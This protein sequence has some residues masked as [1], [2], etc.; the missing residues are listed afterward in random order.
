MTLCHEIPD[1]QIFKTCLYIVDLRSS[2]LTRRYYYCTFHSIFCVDCTMIFKDSVIIKS[3]LP[4]F[5]RSYKNSY[6]SKCGYL[7]SCIFQLHCEEG[8]IIRPMYSRAGFYFGFIRHKH[9][10]SSKD[11][12]RFESISHYSLDL[13][14]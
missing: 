3:I 5:I 12:I 9:I 6:L 14:I 1:Y 11:Q 10:H 4:R 13:Q 2:C 7:F 8:R